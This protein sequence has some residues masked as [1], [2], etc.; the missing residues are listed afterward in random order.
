MEGKAKIPSIELANGVAL[1][2]VGF[3]TYQIPPRVTQ[4][5]VEEALGIG[6]RAVDTAQCYGNEAQVGRAV[7]ASGVGRGDVFV[8]TKIWTDGYRSTKAGIA[9]SASLLGG[10]VDLL[11]VHEPTHDVEG[12]WRA[13][14]EACDEGTAH[15]IGVSNFMDANLDELLRIA[16]TAP[17]VD[18]VETHVYRQ[19]AALKRQL[20]GLGIVLQS[21]SPLACGRGGIFGESVLAEIAHTHGRTVAQVAL[22][23]LLQRGVPLNVKSTHVDR[24]RENLDVFG[25]ELSGDEMAAIANLDIGRSQFGWW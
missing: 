18:Q 16:E 25:F 9:R 8:T 14:E 20:D 22:R 2:M 11:L 21:W 15:A 23:W 5:C 3:G 12:T 24:M 17:M 19:Q 13:L 1:P 4:A 6:Y 10:Y 7:E